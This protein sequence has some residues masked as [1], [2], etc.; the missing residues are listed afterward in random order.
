[1]EAEEEEA[2][3]CGTCEHYEA[4]DAVDGFCRRYPPQLANNGESPFEA[5]AW[6]FPV[7]F[8]CGWCGEWKEAAP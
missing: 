4:Y 5:D 7:V 6:F 1:M 3:R 2:G 8:G